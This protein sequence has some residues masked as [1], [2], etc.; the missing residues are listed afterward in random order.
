MKI[1]NNRVLN[2]DAKFLSL[3]DH[4]SGCPLSTV[5]AYSDKLTMETFVMAIEDLWYTYGERASSKSFLIQK[6]VRA[7][8]VDISKRETLKNTENLIKRI[9]ISFPDI[10]TFDCAFIMRNITMTEE[11][12]RSYTCY[13]T[14]RHEQ[15]S[16]KSFQLWLSSAYRVYK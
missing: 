9:F 10:N 4:V 1:I 6:L 12:E 14:S 2:W 3:M 8:P 15:S 11:T 13:L 16:L 7:E 5:Q